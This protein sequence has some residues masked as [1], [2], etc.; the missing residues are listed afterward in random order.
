VTY[1]RIFANALTAAGELTQAGDPVSVLKLTRIWPLPEE[2]LQIAREYDRVVFFEEGS[3]SGGIAQ[4]FGEALLERGYRGN[5]AVQA[6]DGL[7]P[8]CTV[9]AGLRQAGLDVEGMVQKVREA[10]HGD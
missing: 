2:A 8:A 9:S 1:G 6:I 3:R 5:Y 4:S 10:L 7:I